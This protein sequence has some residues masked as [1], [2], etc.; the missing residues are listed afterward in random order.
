MNEQNIDFG[1]LDDLKSI[2]CTSF[3]EGDWI[4]FKSPVYPDYERR[5]NWKTGE[6]KVKN[7]RIDVLHSGSYVPEALKNLN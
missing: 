6:M 4:V 7:D 2:K 1:S 5:M 3:Q